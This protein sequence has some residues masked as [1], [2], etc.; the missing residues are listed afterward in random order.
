ML[1]PL[2]ST[3][4]FHYAVRCS[5]WYICRIAET[6]FSAT[7]CAI[8]DVIHI[9]QS[10]V[11]CNGN[12]PFMHTA[13]LSLWFALQCKYTALQCN[14]NLLLT[15]AAIAFTVI[16]GNFALKCAMTWKRAAIAFTDLR[17]VIL[18]YIAVAMNY[19]AIQSNSI[20]VATWSELYIAVQLQSQLQLP[21]FRQRL[22]SQICH[23]LHSPPPLFAPTSHLLSVSYL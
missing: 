1:A 13:M 14:V 18:K 7:C 11:S 17:N 20:A 5:D 15:V 19:I 4:T 8:Y 6:M 22:L 10:N 16:Q 3:F 2:S 23:R 9:A 12:R 21:I